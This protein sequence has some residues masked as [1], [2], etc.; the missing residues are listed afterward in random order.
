MLKDN[1]T[2][3]SEADNFLFSPKYEELVAKL[4]SQKIDQKNHG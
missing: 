2:A 4:L 3:F 1:G